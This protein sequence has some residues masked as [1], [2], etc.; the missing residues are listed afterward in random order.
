[1][2]RAR[3]AARVAKDNPILDEIIVLKSEHPAWG[4]R[5]YWGTD[6]TKVKIGSFG[7]VYIHVVLTSWNNPKGI[8]DTE[9]VI[10]TLKEDSVQCRFPPSIFSLQNPSAGYG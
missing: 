1:M 2:K 9:R 6:M 3:S 7:W 10:R 4:Y 5:R 8:A